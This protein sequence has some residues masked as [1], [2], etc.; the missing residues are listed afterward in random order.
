MVEKEGAAALPGHNLPAPLTALG[1]R[2]AE[3][4]GIAEA[5]RRS[6]LV[7]LTG[8]GGVGKTRLALEL[9]RRQVGRRTD[10]VWLVDLASGPQAPNVAAE[11]ARTLDVR[12]RRD[13]S[14]T[15]A[16]QTYLVERDPLLVLDNCEHVVE[17]S[18]QLADTLLTSCP[19]VRIIAT[20]RE[21]L[22][23]GG[24]RV[25]RLEPLDADDARRL[26]VERARARRPEFMPDERT[27]VT[28]ARICER[29]DRLPLA[30]ELAAARVGV[31]SPQE[32]LGGLE[33]RVGSLGG[34]RLVPP[35][36]RA[37]R[38]TVEW[39]H[40]LLDTAEQE[41]LRNLAVFVGGFDAAA[42]MSVAPG[43][44]LEVLARLVE[45]SLVSVS[46]SPSGHT[47][48]RLLETVREYAREL[49]DEA[50]ELDGS[51]SPPWAFLG[52]RAARRG[53][54]ALAGRP[55]LGR[56]APRRLRERAGWNGP[57]R[58]TRARGCRSSSASGTLALHVPR[59]PVS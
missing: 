32:I 38:A 18:A 54:L 8:P 44:T 5:L 36:H 56:G 16:L 11:T 21:V 17:A 58:Q 9:A 59:A 26:F 37:V 50:G 40:K 4:E 12:N 27:D 45:K 52:A 35:R 29:L 57:R 30:I 10:G 34:G 20:S 19:N 53:W 3:L 24:E 49:L 43:L 6:R 48:Y 22:D 46:M 42:A 1:G 31:M 28:I 2:G 55:A 23:V 25:W 15:E 41:A 13:A 47:R 7:T 33:S 14:W 51:G 39:S